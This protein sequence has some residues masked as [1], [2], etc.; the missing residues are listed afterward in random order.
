MKV[1]YQRSATILFYIEQSKPP[2]L[3]DMSVL[4][5]ND[6]N[7][8]SINKLE[9]SYQSKTG[10]N[11]IQSDAQND[12]MVC[13]E[14]CNSK[15]TRIDKVS[16]PLISAPIELYYMIHFDSSFFINS[17]CYSRRMQVQLSRAL[18]VWMQG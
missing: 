2:S 1:E 10:N 18:G 15:Q 9:S 11:N 14:G 12:F 8:N 3:D 6:E 4:S 7:D 16:I 17:L 5:K 13:D